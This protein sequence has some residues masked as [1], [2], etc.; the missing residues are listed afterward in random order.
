MHGNDVGYKLLVTW[1]ILTKDDGRFSYVL[2]FMQ[3][4]LDLPELDAEST[5]LHLVITTTQKLDI[6]VGKET[7]AVTT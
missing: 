4:C 6:P 7:R 1:S 5:N 3:F 2:S